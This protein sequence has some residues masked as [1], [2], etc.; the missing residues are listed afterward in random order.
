MKGDVIYSIMLLIMS[1]LGGIICGTS[2]QDRF[3]EKS[4][5]GAAWTGIVVGAL[6]CIMSGVL[7]KFGLD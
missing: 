7:I 5:S 6:V 3:V 4:K 2:V 1:A